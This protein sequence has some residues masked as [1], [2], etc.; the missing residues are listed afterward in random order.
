ML[1]VHAAAD[2]SLQH[3]SDTTSFP[4]QS[5]AFPQLS[6]LGAFHP[7]LVYHKAN[8]TALVAYAAQRGV[9]IVPEFDLPGHSCFAKSMPQLMIKCAGALDPTLDATY[10]FL[11]RFLKEMTGIFPDQV[12]DPYC[13]S[14]LSKCLLLTSIFPDH[15]KYLALGGDEVGFACAAGPKKAWLAAHNMTAVQLLPYFWKRVSAEVMPFLNRT[16][17]VWGTAQLENLDPAVTPPGTVFNLYTQ[18]DASLNITAKRGV[19]GILS[20]PYYLDQTQS[21]RMG[22]GRRRMQDT[23]R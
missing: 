9:R 8:L 23:G 17:Y 4:V 19:P 12:Q 11:R 7:S 13:V 6:R 20:A 21:Y 14:S 16:L 1:L 18:L 10:A 3:L 22:P 15:F 2:A 5:E